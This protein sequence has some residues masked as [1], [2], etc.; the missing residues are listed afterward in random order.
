[1]ACHVAADGMSRGGRMAC[2]V[3]GGW[4]VTWRADGMSRGGGWHITWRY[5]G[6]SRGG[7]MDGIPWDDP[8]I[9]IDWKKVDRDIEPERHGFLV[10]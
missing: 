5:D 8:A 9:G 3:A 1:M 4:H 2:H 10:L 7:R 6:M